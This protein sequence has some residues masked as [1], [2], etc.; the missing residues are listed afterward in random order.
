MIGPQQLG[1]RGKANRGSLIFMVFSPS[2]VQVCSGSIRCGRITYW[3][4]GVPSRRGGKLLDLLRVDIREKG[5]W[6]VFAHEFGVFYNFGAF[7]RIL[8]SFGAAED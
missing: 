1:Q 6:R 3:A 8:K 7:S 2:P 5:G 4:T